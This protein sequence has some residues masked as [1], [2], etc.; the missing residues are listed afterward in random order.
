MKTNFFGLVI[1][2]VFSL[3]LTAQQKAITLD[4]LLEKAKS[5]PP[6]AAPTGTPEALNEA[7]TLTLCCSDCW[8]SSSVESSRDVDMNMQET[9]R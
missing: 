7:L 8:Y 1:A 5:S 2:L 9:L 6:F 4:A 3:S